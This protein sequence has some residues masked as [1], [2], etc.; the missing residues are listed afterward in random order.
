MSARQNILRSIQVAVIER[1]ARL[2][3]HLD[4]QPAGEF[5]ERML[6]L[7]AAMKA[8]R[9]S[10]VASDDR[11]LDSFMDRT[12]ELRAVFGGAQ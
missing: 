12:H 2:A 9:K 4:V 11:F 6:A 8:T 7:E 5:A 10:S 3:N 1:H